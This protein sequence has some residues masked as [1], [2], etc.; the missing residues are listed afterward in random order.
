MLQVLSVKLVVVMTSVYLNSFFLNQISLIGS[1]FARFDLKFRAV[2]RWIVSLI[3][4]FFPL[5]KQ[6]PQI[7]RNTQ[8]LPDRLNPGQRIS[9]KYVYSVHSQLR[10]GSF[11]GQ[12][13]VK[14]KSTLPLIRVFA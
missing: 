1:V 5:K 7:T 14:N 3:E 4:S 11:A 6:E 10:S 9:K 2:Q 8:I 12:A 13:V